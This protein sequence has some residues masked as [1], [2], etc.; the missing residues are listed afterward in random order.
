[1]LHLEQLRAEIKALS[2]RT[3]E[4][5]QRQQAFYQQALARLADSP[6]PGK[7]RELVAHQEDGGDFALPATDAP[8][9]QRFAS[10]PA[11]P[12]GTTVIAV[13][14]SQI[15]PD[16]HAAVLYY[17]I[18][19]GGLIFC[20]DG[21]TPT[22]HR[23]ATLHFKESELY[24]NKGQII[25]HQLGMR[26][27]VAELAYLAELTAVVRAQGDADPVIA[28]TDGPLL[29]PHSGRTEEEQTL[30][31]KYVAALS[32]L[33]ET[34]ALPAGFVERPGGRP[35]LNTL[36]LLP[37]DEANDD[38]PAKTLA[39]LDDHTLMARYLAPGERT[40]WLKRPSPMNRQHA[41]RGHEIWFC[42]FNA[43]M[44]DHPVIARV[45][46][47]A[48]AAK[49]KD[50]SRIVHAALHHQALILH[51]YPYALARAHELALVTQKDKTTLDN[52]LQRRLVEAGLSPRPSEKSRQKSYLGRRR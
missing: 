25:G 35:L 10:E 41:R 11:P 31:P 40:V 17:L 39:H 26:R 42:Y 9:N 22:Q 48:W 8:L 37:L 21:T 51:G 1:M 33:E 6:D 52:L 13:D 43:G 34:D 23:D 2:E 19:V 16:R 49:G 46:A 36:N 45:E 12:R 4:Q 5:Q 14:G 7:L 32:R 18:Q 47:P 50:W 28:L 29:W 20:Y 30:L 3:V 38:A 27:T 15:M 44:L 24:D